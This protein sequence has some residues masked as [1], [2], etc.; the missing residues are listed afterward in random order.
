M[1]NN[2][3]EVGD[4]IR[5][6]GDISKI[7]MHAIEGHFDF[8][9]YLENSGVYFEITNAN[10]RTII[11]SI[12]PRRRIIEN[13]IIKYDERSKELFK[14]FVFG[15]P[16]GDYLKEYSNTSLSYFLGLNNYFLTTL[17]FG[18]NK[19]MSRRTKNSEMVTLF[20]LLPYLFFIYDKMCVFR[21]IIYLIVFKY[22]RKNYQMSY[23]SCLK[24][25]LIMYLI[26]SPFNIYNEGL[27]VPFILGVTIR[28]INKFKA[29]R[30]IKTILFVGVVYLIGIVKDNS[31]MALSPIYRMILLPIIF[32]FFL[33][34]ILFI[35]I[36]IC[37]KFFDK[38]SSAL[39]RTFDFMSKIDI[40][41]Y[42]YPNLITSMILVI[43]FL[44]ILIGFY[45]QHRKIVRKFTVFLFLSTFML[46]SSIHNYV[47][48]YLFFI[49][50]GQGD[51]ALLIHKN[52]SLLIDTG[53]LLY[54]D[55][56]TTTLIPFFKRYHLNK[57]DTIICSH[58]DYDHIG[59]LTSLKANFNVGDVI[60]KKE[61]FPYNFYGI[62]IIN[63]N[64]YHGKDDN[65]NSL[66][67][68]FTFMDKTFLFMGDASST[69][70]E[71]IVKDY[72]LSYVDIL[73]VS[74]HG[75][76][77]ASSDILLSE[78]TPCVAIISLGFNNIYK[79]PSDE[80]L[81]RFNRYQIEIRRTDIEGTII[82]KKLSF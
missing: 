5:I 26:K 12:F 14:S 13:L 64:N 39:I 32:I 77:T 66:V 58:F 56:A 80:V 10:I 35:P 69:I 51:C 44:I 73:K 11:N 17:F 38:F 25:V 59:A 37:T 45:I 61:S 36:G 65:D 27:I 67:N 46:S 43:L 79:F 62:Q 3:Y 21:L 19:F 4:L 28:F 40:K 34:A 1:K 20:I 29:S 81:N 33:C 8:Q 74:H 30:V 60:T 41:V 49:D 70:E 54:E 24:L 15:M 18:I 76:K 82:Y 48:D 6:S 42:L 50:V 31:I 53:G 23:N 57:I 22:L 55:L 47:F 52:K 2:K 71:K 68:M 63:L 16:R 7:K 72:D 9:N 75:S 78:I